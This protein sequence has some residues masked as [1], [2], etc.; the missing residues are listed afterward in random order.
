MRAF[1][2]VGA[3]HESPFRTVG[4]ACPYKFCGIFDILYVGEDIILP[5]FIKVSLRI[6]RAVE[7]AC[8]YRFLI[9][10]K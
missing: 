3:I 7:D 6:T 10:D 2:L 9:N 4:D 1:L 8:P 5:L